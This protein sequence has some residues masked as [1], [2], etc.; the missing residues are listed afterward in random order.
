M[1][2]KSSTDFDCS[3]SLK[4]IINEYFTEMPSI[5]ATEQKHS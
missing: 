2:Y 4:L 1:G 5:C 3:F